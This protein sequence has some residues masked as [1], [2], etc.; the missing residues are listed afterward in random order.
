MRR[1]PRIGKPAE[2]T[3]IGPWN[4]RFQRKAG[5]LKFGG[6]P[7]LGKPAGPTGIGA[8]AACPEGEPGMLRTI[9]FPGVGPRTYPKGKPAMLST[10]GLPGIG[11]PSYPHRAGRFCWNR[12]LPIETE[13]PEYHFSRIKQLASPLV[14]E[15]GLAGGNG[16]RPG[17]VRGE[18]EG[19]ACQV[20]RAT[21][22]RPR[23]P[24]PNPL[25]PG[26]RGLGG[27]ENSPLHSAKM[28]QR[29]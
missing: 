1:E 17:R 3:G 6:L 16:R 18:S 10:I 28:L 8:R 12:N 22:A 7:R 21:R 29:E 11:F 20:R 23:P 24:H 5:S 9:G 19:P 25:P 26:E 4:N 13:K 2:A 15:A 27:H 14:G